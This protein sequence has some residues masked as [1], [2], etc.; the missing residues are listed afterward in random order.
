MKIK[1][2][3]LDRLLELHAIVDTIGAH[4]TDEQLAALA[5]AWGRANYWVRD[6]KEAHENEL[7]EVAE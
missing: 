7:V 6:F 3:L 2:A 1:Q 5:K 4:P